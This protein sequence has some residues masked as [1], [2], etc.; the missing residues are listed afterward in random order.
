MKRVRT[1]TSTSALSEPSACTKSARASAT[2]RRNPAR[3]D[4]P[5]TT[6]TGTISPMSA[7]HATAGSTKPSARNGNGR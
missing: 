2:A 5:S 1:Y 6:I 3:S 7:S 4:V